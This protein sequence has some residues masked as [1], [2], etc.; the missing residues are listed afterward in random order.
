MAG[1]CEREAKRVQTLSRAAPLAVDTVVEQFSATGPKIDAAMRAKIGWTTSARVAANGTQEHVF[2]VIAIGH[3]VIAAQT[4][5]L[6]QRGAGRAIVVQAETS[7]LCENYGLK[8]KTALCRDTRQAL[9]D[10]AR[11]LEARLAK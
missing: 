7:A 11:R 3:G 1:V 4:V 2:P 9:L 10:I 8:D 5:V 6:V